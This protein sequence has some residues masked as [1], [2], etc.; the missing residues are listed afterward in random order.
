ML[1]DKL[2]PPRRLLAWVGVHIAWLTAWAVVAVC[3]YEFT[4]LAEW[5]AIPWLPVSL[6]GTAVAFYLGFKNNSAYDRMWEA[7]KI[8]GSIVNSSRAWGSSVKSYVSNQF[9]SQ[10]VS[11]DELRAIHQRLVYRHIAWLYALRSQ[12]LLV[13]DWEHAAQGGKT[14]RTAVRYQREF[15]VG[16]I[17]DEITKNELHLFIPKDEFERTINY[18]NTATQ[19]IDQQSMDLKELRTRDLIDDFRHIELQKLLS[20]F[21]THQGKAERIKN[22]PLPRQYANSGSIFVGIFILLLP[23][24]MVSEFSKLGDFGAW[25][26][27]PFIVLV[28][29]VFYMMES[30]GDYSENPFQ[31]MAN[32]IPMFALSRTVEI[33]LREMLGETDLPEA[34]APRNGILM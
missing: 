17:N 4:G 34:I 15:G 27:I 21:Y 20:D 26:S 16:L 9:T 33:D 18:Q 29:W 24:A 13:K 31:G 7:R 1:V 14:G 28:G 19:L 32:D 25:W 30:I 22:F 6:I 23:F 5:L 2:I 3:V 10:D 12:L 8:W 11:T